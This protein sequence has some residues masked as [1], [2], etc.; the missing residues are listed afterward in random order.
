MPP[1]NKLKQQIKYSL[2]F[3]ANVIYFNVFLFAIFI[4]LVRIPSSLSTKDLLLINVLM[5]LSARAL[6]LLLAIHELICT[7]NTKKNSSTKYKKIAYSAE[8]VSAIAAVIIQVIA[9][10]NVAMNNLEIVATNKSII[11]TKGAVDFTCI[12]IRLLITSPLLIYVYY[13]QRK[14]NYYIKNK[15]KI[16]ILFFLSVST[17]VINLIAFIGKIINVLEQ[18]QSFALFNT[19]NYTN[20]G[21]TNFPLGPIIRILCITTNIIILTIMLNI[22]SSINSDVTEVKY[23]KLERHNVAKEGFEPTSKRL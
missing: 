2:A 6:L 5:V 3:S 21:P 14:T 17:L 11:H 13:N 15:N 23:Q 20:N 8:V 7:T 16:D 1:S 22:E 18:T 12:L 4:Q 10:T 19:K 9:V